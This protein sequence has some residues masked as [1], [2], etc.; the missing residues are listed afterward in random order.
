MSINIKDVVA[1]TGAPGLYQVVKSDDRA[2]VV[3][4]LDAQR[5]RQMIKGNMMVSKLADI[6]IYTVEDSEPLVNILKSIKEKYPDTLPVKK[7]SPNPALLSFLEEVLPN[8]DKERVYASNV[9]KLV[10]WY[11]I[12]QEFEVDFELPQDEKEEKSD[13]AGNED[14]AEA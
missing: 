13:S 3:E 8:Y 9:K 10:G 4:S 11:H 5:K 2:V 6:S 12:L 1:I 7:K 14:Q